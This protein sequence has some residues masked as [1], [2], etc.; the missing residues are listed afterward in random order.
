MRSLPDFSG[1]ISVDIETSGPNPSQYS[2]LSLGACFVEDPEVTFYAE[3]KPTSRLA[4]PEAMAIHGLDLEHLRK[5]GLTPEAAMASFE[6]WVR[7]QFPSTRS[8]VFV[9]YNAPFDWMFVCDYFHRTRGHNPFGHTAIDIRAAYFG[10]TA[11]PWR[12]IRFAELAEHYLDSSELTHNA[13]ED[14]QLQAALFRA[15]MASGL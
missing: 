10:R 6:T 8:P 7:T 13:L 4:L 15:I 3:L 14:A 12:E 1:F 11:Q 9:A 5:T 2:M